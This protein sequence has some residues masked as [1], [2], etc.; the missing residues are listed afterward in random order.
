MT[1]AWLFAQCIFWVS[2]F[3]GL[4]FAPAVWAVVH[5]FT[6]EKENVI[7]TRH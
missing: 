1:D 5:H 4:I 2:V 6:K 3:T 7:P